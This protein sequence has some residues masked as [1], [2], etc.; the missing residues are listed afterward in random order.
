MTADGT[1]LPSGDVRHR[2]AI[3]SKAEVT[4]K[5]DFV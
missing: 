2:S 5:S 1:G 3:E 4:W